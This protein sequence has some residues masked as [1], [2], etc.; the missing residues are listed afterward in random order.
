M[1]FV[2]PSIPYM[3][4]EAEAQSDTTPPEFSFVAPPQNG[5]G[6]PQEIY[7]NW[8]QFGNSA[9]TVHATNSTG[10]NAYFGVFA[11]GENA[12][13]IPD[14]TCSASPEPTYTVTHTLRDDPGSWWKYGATFPIGTTTVTCTA[15]DDAGNVGTASLTVIVNAPADTTPPVV[16]VPADMT[17]TITT[18]TYAVVDLSTLGITATDDVGMSPSWSPTLGGCEPTGSHY[19]I[20]TTTVTCT[21]TDD[22]GNQGNASFTITVNAPPPVITFSTG[23]FGSLDTEILSGGSLTVNASNST[24]QNA[25]FGVL[26]NGEEP[27]NNGLGIT[28]TCSASPEPTYTAAWSGTLLDDPSSWWKSGATFPI[29]TTT[30][31]C[32]GT[33]ADGNVGTASLTVIVNAPADTTPPVITFTALPQNGGGSSGTTSTLTVQATNSTGQ[34]VYFH[35]WEDGESAT[36]SATCSASPEPTYT[37]TW[38]QLQDGP[39]WWYYGATFP[40]GTTTVTCTATDDAGNVGT[41]S[42]NVNVILQESEIVEFPFVAPP[43]NGGGWS[44]EIY[45][46]WMQFGDSTLTVDATNSTG[47]NVYFGLYEVSGGGFST[48]DATCSASPEPTYTVTHTLRDDPSSWWKYGATFPIGTTTVTCTV[49]DSDGNVGTASLTVTVN[50]PPETA[51]EAAADAAAAD[52]AADAAAAA[53]AAAAAATAAAAAAE[54]SLAASDA[55]WVEANPGMVKNTEGSSSQN[56]F[57]APNCFI[58]S[59]IAIST[60]DSVT[61]VNTDTAAHT[62][63][64][65]TQADGPDGVFDSS[66]MMAGG[67]YAH[68]FNEA[69]TYDY[70]CMVH[71]WMLGTVIVTGEAGAAVEEEIIIP[72]WIKSNAGWWD[73]GLIDDRNYVTG[74]Q[75]LISNGIMTIPSTEQGT[76]SDDVIPSWVKNNARWWADGSIDDRNYV[77]GLQWLISN[78]VMTIG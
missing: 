34:N 73:A 48:P 8:M 21:A 14:A 63:T 76:G 49:T 18:G 24:G 20:G 31:T 67:N 59:T 42:F 43:Q 26:E 15:T 4:P 1:L 10:Q 38:G 72:T 78:G 9:L 2:P 41:A 69:G 56:S 45:P 5:G 27:W 40:I 52:A 50:A 13:Y 68:I 33:D 75:W 44:Q 17:I 11:D 30:V 55:V 46:N 39:I 60:G 66:L 16:N 22:A 32:T 3:V 37:V 28:T 6:W 29:G 23:G 53:T 58:P 12:T 74:L 7:P 70:F 54:A 36:W 19:Q 51:A 35:V 71:P 77:T 25:Y 64:S 65:G 61:W 62:A 47:Q 57:C